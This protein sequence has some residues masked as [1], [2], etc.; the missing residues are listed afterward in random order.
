[1][2]SGLVVEVD[3]DARGTVTAARVPA[4]HLEVRPEGEA[5]T[6][7]ASREP[8]A[9]VDAEPVE[10]T[11]DGVTLRG[12][13]WLPAE[14]GEA[15]TPVAL[16]IAG[17]GPTDR[18]GN[19]ASGLRTDAYR[20]VAEA[21]ARRGIATLRYDKRG[22][23]QS[24]IDFDLAATVLDDFV[25]DAGAMVARLRGDPRLGPVTLIGHSEGGLIALRLAHRLAEADAPPAALVLVS[26][27]GRPLGELLREQLARQLHE[28]TLAELDRVL[29]AVRADEPLDP[30]PDVLAPLFAP[31][32]RAFWRSTIDVDPVALLADLTIPAHVVQ[33]ETD[34][35]VSM[36]DAERLAGARPDV[37]LVRL[38]ETNHVLK[39]EPEATLP[40]RSYADPAMPL[41]PG[42]VD[43]IAGGVARGGDR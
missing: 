8:P 33:G 25:A 26:T 24:G 41:A 2:A 39:R 13:L 28:A 42:V 10:V 3:L 35:Q 9:G 21:L 18:D 32:V 36:V 23:G 15:P 17:S 11:R 1:M 22:V 27:A 12:E 19:N 6:A 37:V 38:A 43:A 7:V 30:L 5:P 16:W 14:R 40:Q 20:M 29:A 34:V 4:Q 31:P